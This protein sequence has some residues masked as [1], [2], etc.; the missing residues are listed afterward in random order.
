MNIFTS[1]AAVLDSTHRIIGIA[2]AVRERDGAVALATCAHVVM[3]AGGEP[4]GRL[5]VR[6]ALNGQIQAVTVDP[7]AWSPED[8]WDLAMLRM[9]RDPPP[10]FV[11]LALGACAGAEGHAFISFG[12]PQLGEFEGLSARGVITGFAQHASGRQFLQLAAEN[13]A[14]GFSGAPVWDE[15]YGR[16]VGV[17]SLVTDLPLRSKHPYTAFA[18]PAEALTGLA[19]ARLDL[20]PHEKQTVEL[21]M[22][23]AKFR[24]PFRHSDLFKGR[25]EDLERLHDALSQKGRPVGIRPAGLVG[26]GGIGK[27]MLAAEYCHRYR[28]E[29][30]D[31]VFWVNAA[32][33]LFQELAALAEGLNLATRET[34]VDQAVS[35][36][37]G[38]LEVHPRALVVF[39]NLGDPADL[40][41][42]LAPG[43][44]PANLP[45]P[46]L[47]TTR[48]RDLPGDF[49]AFEIQVLPEQAALELLLFDRQ[50]ARDPSHPEHAVAKKICATLG[51]LPLALELARAYLA[52]KRRVTLSG[53]LSRLE[54]EGRLSVVDAAGLQAADL[55]TRHLAAVKATLIQQLALVTDENARRVFLAAGQMPENS[56]IPVARLGL[57]SRVSDQTKPG[58]S[59]GLD[60]ALE[61]LVAFSLVEALT[62]DE[63]GHNRLRLHPI[64]REFAQEQAPD[65]YGSQLAENLAYAYEDPLVLD[66]HIKSRGVDEVLEDLRSGL[67]LARQETIGSGWR[68]NLQILERI[69]DLEAHHL[70]VWSPAKH[71]G[72]ALQQLNNRCVDW[73]LSGLSARFEDALEKC[74]WDHLKER[75]PFNKESGTC[76][77][78]LIGHRSSENIVALSADGRFVISRSLGNTLIVWDTSSGRQVRTL[79]V[80]A[81][82]V[83]GAALSS[84]GGLAASISSDGTL[85]VWDTTSGKNIFS[86]CED[87]KAS[88]SLFAGLNKRNLIGL[89]TKGRIVLALFPSG[90]VRAWDISSWQELKIFK[91]TSTG[92]RNIVLSADGN[93]VVLAL[94]DGTLRILDIVRGKQLDKI[95]LD[96]TYG[97]SSVS[98]SADGLL[99]ITARQKSLTVLDLLNRRR[100]RSWST[101]HK[102]PITSVACSADGRLAV[103]GSSDGTLKVWDTASGWELSTL[104]GHA[105]DVADVALSAD[106]TLAVSI[107]NDGVIKVWKITRGQEWQ[108]SQMHLSQ[109][110]HELATESAQKQPMSFDLSLNV[111]PMDKKQNL[112]TV[113]NSHSESVSAVALSANGDIA[114]SASWD[115]TLK[116]WDTTTNQTLWTWTAPMRSAIL[117]ALSADGELALSASGEG[118]RVWETRSGKQIGALWHQSSGLK[119]IALSG[120]GRTAITISEKG[121]IVVWDMT[122]GQRVRTLQ[123]AANFSDPL[124]SHDYLGVAIR[125]DGQLAI[126]A[127]P[128]NTLMIWDIVEGQLLKTKF[129]ASDLVGVDLSADGRVALCASWNN[130][131]RVWDTTTGK[132]LRTL[133]EDSGSVSGIALSGNGKTAVSVSWQDNRLDVWDVDDVNRS[134]A[135]ISTNGSF[136]CAANSADGRFIVAGDGFGMVHFIDVV[137]WNSLHKEP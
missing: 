33:P 71:P 119:E 111:W 91:R 12:Y 40:N 37:W 5:Q 2:F 58:Y 66:R 61:E 53:Y 7:Q 102:G 16:V 49:Y 67:G 31:G 122:S 39:D 15:V 36:L 135:L 6:L 47:F 128:N 103:T 11:P 112:Q 105:R 89:S 56:T 17:V 62:Q 3:Q 41:R 72:F 25:E 109:S 45:C 123:E 20:L 46:A 60:D 88:P 18:A 34:P 131:I 69:V 125:A 104:T 57:L 52:R 130:T 29:F 95:V 137:R 81:E 83:L 98:M 78:T 13:L 48:R 76:L 42:E 132:L 113:L 26:Q 70:R 136:R 87:F 80:H 134:T 120:D 118:L 101:Q 116:A 38:Y 79:A 106:G 90:N 129:E 44:I 50:T 30:P 86:Y 63:K 9:E 54:N 43:L 35:R 94:S 99:A 100:V 32:N 23:A 64:A 27:T 4:G 110:D 114:L 74:K 82:K 108:A 10:G 84:D 133:K 77:R 22:P 96:N 24:V 55:P 73:K 21:P 1:L 28:D 92:I 126:S 65:T 107:S 68:E 8:E 127:S 19:P 93:R 85:K 124:K 117:V 75:F 14:P 51:Y 59:S 121:E 115:G 97:F